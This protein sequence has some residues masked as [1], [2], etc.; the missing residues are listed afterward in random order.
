MTA[1]VT[2]C[3]FFHQTNLHSRCHHRR[4]KA[5]KYSGRCH[6]ETRLHR[7]SSILLHTSVK[8]MA[9]SRS[10]RF[11]SRLSASLWATST[12]IFTYVYLVCDI[13]EH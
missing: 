6:I 1:K 2:H 13:G 11:N 9:S 4:W 7:T 12:T 3:S 8:P 10:H 5:M